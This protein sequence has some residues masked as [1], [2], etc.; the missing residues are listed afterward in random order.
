MIILEEPPEVEIARLLADA[1]RPPPRLTVSQWAE[2]YRILSPRESRYPGQWS[3]SV[4]PPMADVMDCLSEH[5]PARRVVLMSSAQIGKNECAH[6]FI[7]YVIHLTPGPMMIVSS[8]VETARRLSRQRIASMIQACPEI[9]SRVAP[10][11][12]RDGGNALLQ[13][14]FDGGLLVITGAN[15]AAGLRSMPARF[16]VLDESE[17]YPLDVDGEGDPCD[18]AEARTT[19]YE[20]EEKIF[21]PSTPTIPKGKIHR[22]YLAG[23][24]RQ[25]WVPCMECGEFQRLVW[26]QVKWDTNEEDPRTRH[27][28][29]Y[30]LCPHCACPWT[31][32]MRARSVRKYEWQ[33][34]KPFNG[35]AS[36]EL[37]AAYN[38]HATL[39]RMVAKYEKALAGTL[40]SELA[41]QTAEAG[42]AVAVSDEDSAADV[43]ESIR[44]F[45]NTVLGRPFQGGTSDVD[46][47]GLMARREQYACDPVPWRVLLITVGV[48]VQPDRWEL[49]YVGW[50]L[51]KESWSLGYEVVYGDTAQQ[52]SWEKDLDPHLLREFTHPAGYTLKVEATAIDSGDGNNSTQEVYDFCRSSKRWKRRVWAIKGGAGRRPIMGQPKRIK[53][54]GGVHLFIVGVDIVKSRLA[55]WLSTQKPEQA[56]GEPVNVSVPGYCHFN[57]DWEEAHF[58]QLTAE[59]ARTIYLKGGVP[60][61]IWEKPKGARNERLDCRVY[62]TA[63]MTGLNPNFEQRHAMTEKL[64]E[65]MRARA[66]SAHAG[67]VKAGATNRARLLSAVLPG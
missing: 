28:S 65:D 16:L 66:D 10:S 8:T 52:A 43:E 3:N 54:G 55:R 21:L 23:D 14:E 50:G 37:W 20:G 47:T 11:R 26:E 44:V 42:G 63:A 57:F 39:S 27:A 9:R 5:H 18:L 51:G 24:Q 36:F 19:F 41:E 67:L 15:S 49:E 64:M 59:R 48:D 31:D 56:D 58:K 2:Q 13:K 40:A 4:V 34:R 60:H 33:A 22:E 30:Y 45:E 35:T 25:C 53:T 7:G 29:A 17:S 62:A 6:N 38:T 12:S 46:P 32:A 1:W 61:K